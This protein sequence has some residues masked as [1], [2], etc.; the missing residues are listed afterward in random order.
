M[1]KDTKLAPL[2]ILMLAPEPFF[3][4]RG[5]PISIYFRLKT[6]SEMGHQVDL[7]TY[8]IGEDRHFPNVRIL[9]APAVPG[10]TSIKIGPSAAK[11]PLDFVLLLKTIAR[12][13]THRYDLVFSHEEAGWW[14]TLLARIWGIPHLYDMHSSLP[15]QLDNFE[16]TRSALIKGVFIWLERF[17]LKR[18]GA[19]ITICPDLQRIVKRE[20]FGQKT[21]LLENFL[22]FDHPNYGPADFT[23]IRQ[24]YAPGGEKIALYAGNFQ[25]YQ[26]VARLV[27]AF[28]LLKDKPAVL[29]LVGEK[30]D[31]LHAMKEFVSSLGLTNRVKF[32]G[33][34]PPEKVPLY[35]GAADALV[36]PRLSGTN[37]PLKIYSFLKAGKPVVATR[38]W[39]HTQVVNDRIA[40]L[41]GTDAEAM[42]EGIHSALFTEA[43]PLT[44]AAAKAFADREY[45]P[46]SYKEKLTMA[47]HWATR[48][49]K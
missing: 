29:L 40:L 10:I 31:R 49:K 42:A 24:K 32:T 22:E 38:L 2:K 7:L 19:V 25:T 36:S 5:T 9:R 13:T 27:E 45:S 46:A 35:I 16:F 47:M 37:T 8:P 26:G 3:Q 1:G 34:V 14:G 17:V 33:Q 12:I 20:G 11:L 48:A 4:P 23:A 39:T 30:G 41:T 18:S 15:Q 6:L 21:I 28:A 43:G 44:A